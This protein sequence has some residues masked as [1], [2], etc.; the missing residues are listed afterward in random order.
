MKKI[1]LF[2]GV[3]LTAFSMSC[4][5]DADVNYDAT[6]KGKVNL[7]VAF[8]GTRV[9]LGDKSG[10]S[11]PV[12][13]SAGDKV[14]VNGQEVD[15]PEEAIGKS[16]VWLQVD[17]AEA[18]MVVYPA[19]A[20]D[21]E[22]KQFTTPAVQDNL[23]EFNSS[24][25]V[26]VGASET[27]QVTLHH[28]N[29][30]VKVLL[31][32]VSASDL[33][34][35]TLIAEGGENVAGEF[36]LMS[37]CGEAD[38]QPICGYNY[39]KIVDNLAYDGTGKAEVIFSVPAQNYAKGF[40]LRV[41]T[42]DGKSQSLTAYSATGKTIAPASMLAMSEVDVNPTENLTYISTA[43]ELN[44][45]LSSTSLGTANLDADITLTAQPAAKAIEEGWTFDG[46]GHTITI[47]NQ[48]GAI[49]S[50]NAGT[51]RNLNLVTECTATPSDCISLLVADNSGL[52]EQ[53]R[54]Y[55]S[56]VFSGDFATEAFIGG[57]C[58]KS[59]GVILNCENNADISLTPTT[60]SS[61]TSI[62]GV[63][64]QY[65]A[66][67]ASD[68][69]KMESCV[70][71]GIV[72]VYYD[73]K[74]ST[75]L[76]GGVIGGTSGAKPSATATL[77]KGI[78]R[79]LRNN[80]A[81]RYEYTTKGSG[82]Y[83]CMGGVAGY[84][85][86]VFKDNFNYGEVSFKNPT[87]TGSAGTCPAAA[88]VVGVSMFGGDNLV[89]FGPVNIEG[90]WNAGTNGNAYTGNTSSPCFAGVV[91]RF[92][93]Y[94]TIGS[95][96]TNCVNNGKITINYHKAAT[97]STSSLIA[98]VGAYGS[99]TVVKNCVNNGEMEVI[100][101]GKNNYVGGIVG[102]LGG[103]ITDCTNNANISL[104]GD[105]A[106]TGTQA[107]AGIVAFTRTKSTVLSN[108]RNTGNLEGQA[109]TSTTTAYQYVA[110]IMGNY[111]GNTQ[112]LSKCV[113]EGEIVC[114]WP[115]KV[116]IGGITA[117]IYDS[118][119]TSPVVTEEGIT[120]GVPGVNPIT[121]CVNKGNITV[122]NAANPAAST[123]GSIIG[124]IGAYQSAG[125][126]KCE[127]LGN[128]TLNGCDATAVA[129]CIAG[130]IN[131][132]YSIIDTK[133][134]MTITTDGNGTASLVTGCLY[135]TDGT[136]NFTLGA[137][138]APLSFTSTTAINGQNYATLGDAGF[139][140]TATPEQLALS[141]NKV[142]V[143]TVTK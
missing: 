88:G 67:V 33:K 107:L 17:E 9:A 81:V 103:D 36:D 11:Y 28:Y 128:I 52:I 139:A 51:I 2:L 37:M 29:G 80:G 8:D 136:T 61:R 76:I 6:P 77:N 34:A 58:A 57:I 30:Y 18:F 79:N 41:E 15:I 101:C 126:L 16:Q 14:N 12:V 74:P 87:D 42:V 47:Q 99:T 141:F 116:R 100:A 35:V 20:V 75:C 127:S 123:P 112:K 92:G 65:A 19:S 135:T 122:N 143:T 140:L 68:G 66:T 48:T 54:T 108:L 134:D 129:G 142:N 55:G 70:N 59:T 39:K 23:T 97:A 95:E 56:M 137:E 111:D 32:K 45:Y 118:S 83:M 46:C 86:G 89:N 27:P 64:G 84:I 10:T 22:V 53:V 121:E 106:V 38:V 98:G 90:T 49:F 85:E 25:C 71:N 69:T 26:M 117:A 73:G 5:K 110:G 109:F 21:P 82:T 50:S 72:S 4:T 114:S 125:C 63:L 130:A 115:L 3:A 102:N 78:F 93:P 1:L 94:N 132:C 96:L 131:R 104:I 120:P 119:Q 124:G 138:E 113:N 133:V 44:E 105:S 7:A 91:G 43:E 40:R 13:W 60:I 31:N 62:G 24:M